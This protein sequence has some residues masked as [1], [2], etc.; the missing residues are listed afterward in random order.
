MPLV[1]TV[2][3]WSG[4]RAALDDFVDDVVTTAERKG[5]EVKGP[6]TRP[7]QTYR[8][9]LYKRADPSAGRYSPWEYT[10]YERSLRLSGHDDSVR[11]IAGHELPRSVR[12]E[13]DISQIRSTGST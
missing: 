11:Q 8:V 9:P 10:V 4:D 1:T 7:P 13:I 12:L 5:I 6:H 3:V 2:T